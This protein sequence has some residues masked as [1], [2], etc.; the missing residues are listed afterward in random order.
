[1]TR[2]RSS[3]SQVI[4]EDDSDDAAVSTSP[5]RIT[6]SRL[7]LSKE[8]KTPDPKTQ[9]EE[10]VVE[11]EVEEEAEEEEEEVEEVKGTEA[12]SQG[13]WEALEI[14]D[15]TAKQYFIKWAGTDDRGRPWPPSW[16]PKSH[17]NE[18]LKA[19]WKQHGKA[20]CQA[21]KEAEKEAKKSKKRGAKRKNQAKETARRKQE[22]GKRIMKAKEESPDP[23]VRVPNHV[24]SRESP[25]N[26]TLTSQ[27]VDHSEPTFGG[28]TNSESPA[29]P[30]PLP[31]KVSRKRIVPDSDSSAQSESPERHQSKKRKSN[32]QFSK[33]K[34]VTFELDVASSP[35]SSVPASSQ[36]AA[37]VSKEQGGAAGSQD[38]PLVLSGESANSVVPDSQPAPTKDAGNSS[39][40][41]ESQE[42]PN[43][44]DERRD[45]TLAVPESVSV[46]V[47]GSSHSQSYPTFD[48]PGTNHSDLGSDA[49]R[50]DDDVPIFNDYSQH[51]EDDV[52]E[53]ELEERETTSRRGSPEPGPSRFV[54]AG[55]ATTVAPTTGRSLGAVPVP[56]AAAFFP[57]STQPPSSQ[58]DPIEDP[59]SSP[60]RRS[61]QERERSVSPVVQPRGI[62]TCLELVFGPPEVLESDNPT[63]V[64]SFEAE[65]VAAAALS[66]VSSEVNAVRHAPQP[67]AR[68]VSTSTH[69]KRPV[70]APIIA[71]ISVQIDSGEGVVSA[72]VSQPVLPESQVREDEDESVEDLD[73]GGEEDELSPGGFNE[74]Y[75][76][77]DLLATQRPMELEDVFDYA[78]GLAG[79][80]QANGNVVAGEPETR[81]PAVDAAGD[82]TP[83]QGA[84]GYVYSTQ[85]IQH[86][87][88]QSQPQQQYYQGSAP[89][90]TASGSSIAGGTGPGGGANGGPIGGYLHPHKRDYEET[91]EDS[92]KRTRIETP[93]TSSPAPPP[94]LEGV[95]DVIDLVRASSQI[96]NSDGTKDEI[97]R[98]LNNPRSYGD[99]PLAR[100]DFWAFELRRQML[101][102]GERVDFIIL[103]T[104]DGTF[105]LK[106]SPTTTVPVEFARSLNHAPDRKRGQTP[107]VDAVLTLQASASAPLPL[108][109]AAMTREQL[110]QEVAVLRAQVSASATELAS[111]RPLAE[112]TTRLKSE[113]QTLTSLNKQL[114]NSRDS[115]QQDMAYIQE[116]YSIASTAASAR[117]QEASIAEAEAARLQ[118]LLDAGLKQKAAF[119]EAG[120][121]RWKLEVAR[122]K[123][124]VESVR[125]ERRKM[126]EQGIREKAGKWDEVVARQAS[127]ARDEKDLDSEEEIV[128]DLLRADR[129]RSPTPPPRSSIVKLV[130]EDMSI[131]TPSSVPDSSAST[132]GT[133]FRCEWRSETQVDSQ[134]FPSTTTCGALFPSKEAL[135]N[136]VMTHVST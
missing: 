106:R 104:R 29:P 116:Q 86:Q 127:K 8:S 59:D 120:V 25:T 68:N 61:Q 23:Q 99:G 55:R 42:I 28:E 114:K 4:V 132:L 69:V 133:G 1:M 117:A 40:E 58:F 74:D 119:Y 102:V 54:S 17:A 125:V 27:P 62:K 50:G 111:L 131:S 97:V 85:P 6:R 7:S 112:E 53:A 30:L 81:S 51:G 113:V 70:S 110:E 126:H 37:T 118:G 115:A 18:K 21:R 65:H 9:K 82:G 36:N 31:S 13:F 124:E 2:R 101:D 129:P 41:P 64:S 87:P 108:A 26:E 121:A 80:E 130:P 63:P 43:P 56:R 77:C 73:L 33:T 105:K 19:E 92:A 123:K 46:V 79:G 15:E 103:Y 71:P 128:S 75:F 47:S 134:A 135:S 32:G 91:R 66:Y 98:F 84:G 109:V 100:A 93:K 11:E 24:Q 72:V 16:E 48:S 3:R 88:D 10:Q 96:E 20:K 90:Y 136:H 89:G 39:P 57:A 67:L 83:Q 34:Q 95:N 38:G 14:I 44:A 78:G 12:D 60:F 5:Q 45:D 122:M 107:A 52:D 35:L 94:G 76:D 22:K 49:S